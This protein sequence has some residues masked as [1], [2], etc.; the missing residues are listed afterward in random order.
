[1]NPG[2]GIPETA[3]FAAWRPGARNS[4]LRASRNPCR[5]RNGFFTPRRQED[6]SFQPPSAQREAT[7]GHPRTA[8]ARI[9]GWRHSL[10]RG[11][12]PRSVAVMGAIRDRMS[13]VLAGL[14]ALLLLGVLGTGV[15]A[16]W[17]F[18]R[19][20]AASPAPRMGDTPSV[21][22][23]VQGLHQLVSVKY[24][25]EKVVLV[26]DAKW[27]GETRLLMVAHGVAKAGVD[28]SR[29]DARAVHASGRMARVE[30]PR[31]QLTDVYLDER[32]TQVVE[33]TTGVLR[34]FDKDLEQDA[35]RQAIDQVRLA[36]REAG[37]LR[38]AEERARLQVSA[39]FHQ[40]GFDKVEVMFR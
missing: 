10:L 29:L 12:N 14:V 20:V 34:T 40:S 6:L 8:G 31:P 7:T 30:L 16:G 1:M 22:T 17:W 39:L 5:K 28:L 19:S 38:D 33:R 24:V 26:E 13:W 36:V 25:V 2:M 15:A 35:R 37:I 18:A 11:A 4:P 3:V 21:V 9:R 27:Y 32:R 23:R